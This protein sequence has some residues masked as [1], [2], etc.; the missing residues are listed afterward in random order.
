MTV[1]MFLVVGGG[2]AVYLSQDAMRQ[3]KFLCASKSVVLYF[4]CNFHVSDARK[5]RQPVWFLPCQPD[6]WAPLWSCVF[7]PRPPGCVSTPTAR[8]SPTLLSWRRPQSETQ[9]AN[10]EWIPALSRVTTKLREVLATLPDCHK[11]SD[12]WFSTRPTFYSRRTKTGRG[13]GSPEATG[14]T[15]C[16]SCNGKKQNLSHC[17]ST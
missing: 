11:P 15:R 4:R 9:T 7:L 12:V 14:H 13:P 1:Y 8:S 5:S 17:M 3:S 10:T 2:T 16:A 6:D